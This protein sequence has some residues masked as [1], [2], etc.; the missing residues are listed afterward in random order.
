ML[1]FE[2]P[3]SSLPFLSTGIIIAPLWCGVNMVRI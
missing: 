1:S 3:Y 2:P